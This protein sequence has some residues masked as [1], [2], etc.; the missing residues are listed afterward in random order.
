ML[1]I[2]VL[3]LF[4]LNIVVTYKKI[5]KGVATAYNSGFALALLGGNTACGARASPNRP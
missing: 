5:K 4:K 2:F 3:R 1:D